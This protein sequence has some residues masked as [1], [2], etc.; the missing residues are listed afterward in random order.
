[1]VKNTFFAYVKTNDEV[2]IGS[3]FNVHLCR[4]GALVRHWTMHFKAKHSYFKQLS[5]SVGNF[6]N[7]THSL[8]IETSTSPVLL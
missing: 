8:A 1:M 5:H 6:V 3:N 2:S 7:I 4:F